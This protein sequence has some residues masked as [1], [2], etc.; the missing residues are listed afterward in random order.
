[1]VLPDLDFSTLQDIPPIQR[2]Y[3][4]P[5]LTI[6]A[7]GRVSLNGAMQ[8]RI[9]E[10]REFQAKI[11]PDGRYLVLYPDKPGNIRFS[12]KGSVT[13]MELKRHLEEMGFLMPLVYAMDWD[14]EHKAWIDCCQELPQPP[15][16]STLEK[17][18]R[19]GRKAKNI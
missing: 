4:R 17:P 2:H 3:D 19:T 10:H 12:P 14:E 1:M 9:G 11:S 18:R 5:W 13:H 16:V 15:D 7:K 6:T 8:K